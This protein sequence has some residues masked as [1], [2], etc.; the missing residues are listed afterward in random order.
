MELEMKKRGA[1]EERRREERRANRK[2][3]TVWTRAWILRRP[4][5]G[6]YEQL[7]GELNREDNFLRVDNDLFGKLVH[8]ITPRIQ[9]KHTRYR[10][11]LPA[12]LKLAITLRYLASGNT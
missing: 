8:C 11:A 6:N 9:K 10:K 2:K 12:G 7:L 3:R 4:M 1:D 5:F